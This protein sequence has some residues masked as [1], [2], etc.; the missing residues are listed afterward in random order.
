MTWLGIIFCLS[1]S[2]CFSGL[3]LALFSVSRLRLEIEAAEGN[4]SALKLLKLRKDSNF[5][6]TTVLWGNVGINVLLTL[7]SSSV[8]LGVTA[9]IFSTFVITLGG[10]ILPQAYFSR[11]AMRMASLLT[12]LLRF[13]QILL[14]VIAKPCA[15]LLD[16]WLGKEGIQYLRE[17]ELRQLIHKHMDASETDLDIVEGLGALNFLAIDDVT[18]SEEGE[19][20][21]DNTVLPVA[22]Q[23]GKPLFIDAALAIEEA[24]SAFVKQ[25]SDVD[26]GWVIFID[27]T[28][29]P[30][31]VLST[32]SYLRAVFK[33]GGCYLDPY[34]F[35]HRPV[36]VTNPATRLGSVIAL[37]KAQQEAQSDEPLE[38]DVILLWNH[39]K[40][41]IT[42]SDVL[43][44][45]LKG[46]GLYSRLEH[47]DHQQ[48]KA[49]LP[50][51]QAR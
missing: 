27:E 35:C 51:L 41:I 37:L 23:A 33:A 46:I 44:R 6:L 39:E 1:Q 47:V 14:F 12:P 30:Q 24:G 4:K 2:A 43:G 29:T 40:R 45:L 19:V 50:D 32:D 18:V 42:G 25:I 21:D 16:V 10:E 38:Q 9:F 17:K 11:N 7:L 49:P 8:M 5:L 13:Y 34:P 26:R 15:M 31:W 48:S 36:V 28:Q 20:I 22:T 3:N